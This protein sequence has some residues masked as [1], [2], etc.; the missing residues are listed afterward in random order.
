MDNARAI[1][2]LERALLLR[3]DNGAAN[4]DYAQALYNEGQLFPALE[5]NES[6]INRDDIPSQLMEGLVARQAR[7]RAA[8]SDHS[9]RL[10]LVG[11][12]T[13]ISTARLTP[14]K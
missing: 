11:G 1:E 9:V 14:V 8:T 3:P 10:D 2:S 13:I 7:W 5:I 12:M 4:I 6:L